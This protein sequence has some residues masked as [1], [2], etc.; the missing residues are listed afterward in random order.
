MK[1]KELK[2][3]LNRVDDDRNNFKYLRKDASGYQITLV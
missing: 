2:E 3:F 1:V